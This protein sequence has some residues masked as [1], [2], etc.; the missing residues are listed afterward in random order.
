VRRSVPVAIALFLCLAACSDATGGLQRYGTP[1]QADAIAAEWLSALVGG[2]P[3]RG[4]GLLH[5]LAQDRLYSGD[6]SAYLAE[7]RA[8]GWGGFR[9]AI[10]QPTV[11]DGNYLVT[12]AFPDDQTPADELAKGHLI[13]LFD[14]DDG[15]QRGAITVR[16]DASG[17]RGVL[18]P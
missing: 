2:S 18:G 8:I 1:A 17:T 7:V 12:I 14:S 16:I 11:W 3:D 6:S 4:W 15:T 5:P 10:Q 13:Q 9:W